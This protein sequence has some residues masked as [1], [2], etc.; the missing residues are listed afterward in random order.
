MSELHASDIARFLDLELSGP[1]LQ[2]FGV[3][4]QSRPIANTLAFRSGEWDPGALPRPILVLAVTSPIRAIADLTIIETA[5][6]REAYARIVER[7]F[8]ESHTGIASTAVV[9]DKVTIE[10][11]VSIGE[12]AVI[13]DGVHI[14]AGSHIESGALIGSRTWIGKRCR[15]GAHAVIGNEGL[16]TFETKSGRLSNTRHLGRVHIGDDVEIGA[17][18]AVA[19]G[20]IDETIIG[21]NT[22]IGPM[23]NIGHNTMIGKSCQIAGRAHLSGS[24]IIEDNVQLWANCIIKDGVRVGSRAVVGIGAVVTRHVRVGQTV[25]TLPAISLKSLANFIFKLKWGS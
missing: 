3:S 7:F 13:E 6:P 16:S 2:I 21:E 15:I 9:G 14:G 22:Y 20:T 24:V 5:H 12:G 4:S 10:E 18:C 17:M 23:V 19:R 11:D 1:N 25:V 8:L